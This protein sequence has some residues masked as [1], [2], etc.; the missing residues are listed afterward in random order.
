MFQKFNNKIITTTAFLVKCLCIQYYGGSCIQAY[1]EWQNSVIDGLNVVTILMLE[2]VNF[3]N[4]SNDA[5]SI[6][7]ADVIES[8]DKRPIA[9]GRDT[10]LWRVISNV[11]IRLVVSPV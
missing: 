10:V 1:T 11:I 2:F 8:Q 3:T 4:Y 7:A 5:V 6:I 9:N